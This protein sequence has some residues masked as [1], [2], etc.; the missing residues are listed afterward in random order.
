MDFAKFL[1]LGSEFAAIQFC[2]GRLEIVDEIKGLADV[3]EVGHVDD[4]FRGD[5]I[6]R[7]EERTAGLRVAAE[8]FGHG[9]AERGERHHVISKASTGVD[10]VEGTV[11]VSVRLIETRRVLLNYDFRMIASLPDRA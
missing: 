2:V 11:G 4:D 9:L 1:F 5:A 10:P 7:D 8:A 3:V 6:L